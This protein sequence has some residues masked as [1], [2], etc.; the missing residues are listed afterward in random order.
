MCCWQNYIQL[1][2]PLNIPI[3]L[4]TT[5]GPGE[6]E[7]QEAESTAAPEEAGQANLLTVTRWDLM[8]DILAPRQEFK[9]PRTGN[10]SAAVAGVMGW[11]VGCHSMMQEQRLFRKKPFF[12]CLFFYSKR[13]SSG[14]GNLPVWFDLYYKIK[15]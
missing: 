1:F 2:C 13:H 3:D 7:S 4:S 12:H 5:P 6:S 15:L 8:L 11:A 9:L 14:S 10:Q